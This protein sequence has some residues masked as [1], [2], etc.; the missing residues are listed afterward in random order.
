MNTYDDEFDLTKEMLKTLNEGNLIP[1]NNTQDEMQGDDGSLDVDDD[2]VNGVMASLKEKTGCSVTN[3]NITIY[4]NQKEGGG[5]VANNAIAKLSINTPIK[6]EVS[7]DL[8]SNNGLN[9]S[10]EKTRLTTEGA[11]VLQK[12]VGFYDAWVI[13]W[14]TKLEEYKK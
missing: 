9:I 8:D 6:A 10:L 11:T 13:E 3:S 14:G 4:M 1:D 2:T 12:L 5:T 7:M